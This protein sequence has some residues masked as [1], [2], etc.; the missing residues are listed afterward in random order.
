MTNQW[1]CRSDKPGSAGIAVRD[2]YRGILFSWRRCPFEYAQHWHMSHGDTPKRPAIFRMAAMVTQ[3]VP[4]SY[5][6]ICCHATLNAAATSLCD[7][8]R[9]RLSDLR[10]AP[11]TEFK[12]RSTTR[13][14]MYSYSF[15]LPFPPS[16]N[17][18]W[19]YG[20]GG[21]VYLSTKYS[22]WKRQC[23]SAVQIQKLMA[24]TPVLGEYEIKLQL[25][26]A[27]IR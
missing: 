11:M 5:F 15:W 14:M 20:A 4:F 17:R 23:D 24:G 12:L 1:S 3:D 18:L 27:F 25:S 2:R 7:S 10:R 13:P 16:A 9:S 6:W 26:N 19:R 21:K 22:K 8:C